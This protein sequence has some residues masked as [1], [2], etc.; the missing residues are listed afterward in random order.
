[1]AELEQDP[2]E[3]MGGGVRLPDGSW[4]PKDHPA[5]AAQSGMSTSQQPAAE[6]AAPSTNT[7]ASSG[8]PAPPTPDP[9]AASGGGVYNYDTGGWVPKDHPSAAAA[10]ATA[11][12]AAASGTSASGT[13]QSPSD[14]ATNSYLEMAQQGTTIDR[15]DPNFRQQV[16]PYAAAV[17]RAR[18]QYES[19]SAERLSA[20]GLGSSGAMQNERRLGAERAGQAV[21]SFESQLVARELQNR[22]AEIQTAL[23]QLLKQGQFEDAQVLQ[24]ELAALDAQL[25]QAGIDAQLSI[26][27]GQQ[28]LQKELGMGG[29]N[30]DMLRLLMSDQQFADTMGFNVADREAY[31]NNQALQSLI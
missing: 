28:A 11:P 30:I 10:Q 22:R 19:E 3:A 4:V 2:F 9:F 17:E 8:T 21:G 31:Y 29:L 16:D 24:R 5:A 1:M 7:A 18:R 23:D 27:Q 26:A 13:E 25:K 15:N 6:T 20:R 12:G 14:V